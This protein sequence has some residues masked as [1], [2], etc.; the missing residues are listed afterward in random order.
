LTSEFPGKCVRGGAANASIA[1]GDDCLFPVSFPEPGKPFSPQWV[2]DGSDAN[3]KSVVAK[4]PAAQK[5]Q[6]GR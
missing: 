1:A 5:Q 2:N 6:R 3:V 4:G